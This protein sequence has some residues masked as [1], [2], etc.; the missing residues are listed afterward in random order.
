MYYLLFAILYLV[1]L[2]PFRLLYILSDFAFFILYHVVG[3]RKNIVYN[4]LDIAF[5]EKSV[6][7]KKAIMKKFYKNL[8]DTFIET[9]K[10]LSISEKIFD[11][12]IS[13]DVS[14]LNAL[15]EKGLSI[16]VHSGHQMNWEMAHLA[17]SKNVKIPWVG[18][19]MQIKNSSM[20]KL[21]LK[22]R[23]KFNAVMLAAGDFKK[24]IRNFY[25]SQYMLALIADQN[26]GIPKNAQ[27]LYFFNRPAPFLGGPEKGAIRNKTAVVFANFVKT[28]RGYY[29][30]ETTVITEDASVMQDGE[31]TLL[32]R[33]FLE[34]SICKQPDNY[35][36]SHRRWKIPY[37]S[38][39]AKRWIDSRPAPADH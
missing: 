39:Y 22:I 12:H 28:S 16:Q 24:S 34:E 21:F 32:Y 38:I 10:L 2:L 17:F 9:I 19:Y 6:E 30:F 26:P 11:R 27:W 1:S 8:T 3:Y 18:V 5:P 35:L 4:N 20:N 33:D 14:N 13:I 37:K 31:L 23:R 25:N 36:W 15:A 7:E 29:R